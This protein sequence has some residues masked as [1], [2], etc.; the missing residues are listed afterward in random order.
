MRKYLQYVY[1]CLSGYVQ[2]EE[3]DEIAV[4]IINQERMNCNMINRYL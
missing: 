3:V 4:H 2:K 1:C